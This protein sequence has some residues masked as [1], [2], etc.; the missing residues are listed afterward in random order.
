MNLLKDLKI[1]ENFDN[2]LILSIIFF[3]LKEGGE[4]MT[5]ILALTI[6]LLS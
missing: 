3:L 6:L 1:Q 5:T 4:D 2:I